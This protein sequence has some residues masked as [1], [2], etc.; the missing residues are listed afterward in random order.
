MTGAETSAKF[1]YGN[2]LVLTYVCLLM[3]AGISQVVFH[4]T[5]IKDIMKTDTGVRKGD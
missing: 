2:P 5:F 4:G 1:C 3:Q